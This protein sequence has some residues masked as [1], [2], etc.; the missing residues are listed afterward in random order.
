MNLA[1]TSTD[2]P[3]P[4]GQSR[5]DFLW[6]NAG[7]REFAW[8]LFPRVGDLQARLLG[9]LD[10]MLTPRSVKFAI[11][12]P[13]TLVHGVPDHLSGSGDM[14]AHEIAGAPGVAALKRREDQRMFLHRFAPARLRKNRLVA[15][16][17]DAG[18]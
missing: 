9:A 6:P 2:A 7:M 18:D 4:R 5:H 17:T 10:Q 13:K 1:G 11:G 14:L 16:A 15:G 3:M 8:L 12:S